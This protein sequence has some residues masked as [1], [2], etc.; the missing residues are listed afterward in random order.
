MHKIAAIGEILWDKFPDGK[1]LGGAPTNFAL[2][3]K[4]LGNEATVISAIGDDEQGREMLAILQSWQINT[5]LLQL[6]PDYAT[7]E[8]NV[9]VDKNGIPHY[10]IIENRACDHIQYL[11]AMDA[12][13]EAFD[14]I[15]FGSLSGRSQESKETIFKFLSQLS[16]RCLKACDL[17]IR[18]NYYN[19][20]LIVALLEISQ[21]FKINE[22]EKAL[23]E[24]ILKIKMDTPNQILQLMKKY[25]L[26]AMI[27]TRGEIDSEIITLDEYSSMPSKTV[28]VVDTVGAGDSFLAAFVDGYLKNLPLSQIHRQAVELSAEVCRH[29]GATGIFSK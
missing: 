3:S 23:L 25:D 15:S 20:D 1:I 6:R 11:P 7:G 9:T 17:N 29:K 4:Y 19:K 27:I 14:A 13:S 2:F 28:E 8:V 22:N 10:Q 18:K 24:Q 5:D 16:S 26:K 21:I 12:C